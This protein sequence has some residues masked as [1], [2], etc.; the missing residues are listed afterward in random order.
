MVVELQVPTYVSVAANQEKTWKISSKNFNRYRV[1]AKYYSFT[2]TQ[3][4]QEQPGVLEDRLEAEL[5]HILAP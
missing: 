2:M 1:H 5:E 3:L 4:Q